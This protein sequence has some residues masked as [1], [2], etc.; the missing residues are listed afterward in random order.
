MRIA[1]GK[2]EPLKVRFLDEDVGGGLSHVFHF[3]A[4][5]A[6]QR[7]LDVLRHGRLLEIGDQVDLA[8]SRHLLVELLG[9]RP[10]AL[11]VRGALK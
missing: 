7:P 8:A 6:V 1:I 10:Q 9:R 11:Q 4:N 2:D 5:I 3:Q